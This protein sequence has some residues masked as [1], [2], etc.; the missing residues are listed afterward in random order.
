MYEIIWTQQAKSSYFNTLKYWNNRNKSTL[1]SQKI[2]REVE[3][4]EFAIIKKPFFLSKYHKELN[5]Y[6]RLF[7]KQKF[8]LFYELNEKEKT[9]IVKHFRSNQ[10]KPLK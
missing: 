1:Y 7:F 3:N 10:Q 5:L 9:I 6:Q 2:I 4:L 8:S